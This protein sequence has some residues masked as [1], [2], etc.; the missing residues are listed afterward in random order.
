MKAIAFVGLTIAASWLMVGLYFACGGTW[1]MPG[2]LVLSV[3]YMFVPMTVAI[4]VQK[5]LFKSSVRELGFRSGPIGGFLLL[6]FFRPLWPLPP[7]QF[8]CLSPEP[9]SQPT[10]WPCSN[11]FRA[12]SLKPRSKQMQ[13]QTQSLPVHPFWLGL[14]QGL[15]AGITV[16]AVA[17]FGKKLG[18]GACYRRNWRGWDSGGHRC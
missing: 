6:G 9:P 10:P 14:I 12:C 1:T 2:S 8:P 17:A 3:I 11:G 5:L 4:I 16:N 13:A 7:S 18:C 15:I